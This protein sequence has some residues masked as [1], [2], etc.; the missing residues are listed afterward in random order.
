MC[1]IATKAS[2]FTRQMPVILRSFCVHFQI[3]LMEAPNRQLIILCLQKIEQRYFPERG[4]TGGKLKQRDLEYL[5]DLMVERSGTRISLSTMKRLWKQEFQKLPHTSTLNALAT[6]LHYDHWRAFQEEQLQVP[7]AVM[8]KAPPFRFP[9]KWLWASGIIL[10]LMGLVAFW[11][12]ASPPDTVKV[13]TEITFS[14]DK[15]VAYNV[16]NTV[17]FNYDVSGVAADSFFIQRSW[18]PQHK[19]RIDS[20]KEYFSEIYY[21]PGFH[22]ARLM[23][24]EEVIRKTRIH[25]QTDGWFATAN[26]ERLQ[27]VPTYLD[28]E[29]LEKDGHLGISTENFEQSGFD[30]SGNLILSYFNIRAFEELPSN[31]FVLEARVKYEDTQQLICPLAEL[32]IIDESD[33]SWLSIIQK[34]CES[35]LFLKVG[36][37]MLSGRENDF[38]A[39]GTEMAEW[40]TIKLVSAD[41]QLKCYLNDQLALE[42]PFVGATGRIMGLV[43]TFTGRGLVDY[44]RLENLEGQVMYEDDF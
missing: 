1:N 38:S 21:Y 29:N 8:E 33:A 6:L 12:K 5:I 43:F 22:W 36:E 31:A 44:V 30:L 15:T 23:A 28:Q 18:N 11:P 14:A 26:K 4:A 32:K 35:N 24:N 40:Q 16:P 41:G 27:T 3:A 19:T 20:T 34:G 25:V 2:E 39:L 10:G 17:I 42:R 9:K 37:A 7:A 13:P